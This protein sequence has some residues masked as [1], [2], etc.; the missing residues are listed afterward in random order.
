M[1]YGNTLVSFF[2]FFFFFCLPKCA[3]N[4]FEDYSCDFVK[5]KEDIGRKEKDLQTKEN[6]ELK[7]AQLEER[8]KLLTERKDLD[9]KILKL[10]KQASLLVDKTE[11][12]KMKPIVKVPQNH[13]PSYKRKERN[14]WKSSKNLRGM[15]LWLGVGA[16]LVRKQRGRTIFGLKMIAKTFQALFGRNEGMIL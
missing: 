1:S 13:A 14:I 15:I 8:I 6:K 11:K 12:N 2:F 10:E 9:D 16:T 7:L 3:T 5:R 4:Y